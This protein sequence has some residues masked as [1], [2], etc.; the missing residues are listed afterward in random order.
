V[1]RLKWDFIWHLR[2]STPIDEIASAEDAL[3]RA[4]RLLQQQQKE[5]VHRTPHTIGYTSALWFAVDDA[6]LEM[7]IFDRGRFWID[8]RVSG[9]HLNFDLSCLNGFLFCLLFS[10]VVF[11]FVLPTQGGI[12]SG[13]VYASLTFCWLY[14]MNM[15]LAWWRIPR[16]IQTAV[17][18][19]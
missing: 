12:Y 9:L 4:E 19:T 7:F 11:L 2:G 6:R 16:M 13:L 8:R 15:L 17:N 10:E 14:G 1:S 18:P 5:I 3:Q